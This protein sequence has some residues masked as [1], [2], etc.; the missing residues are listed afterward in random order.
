MAERFLRGGRL[1]T[2]R[3]RRQFHRCG[4][5]GVAVQPPR[6]GKAGGGLVARRRRGGGHRAG[7]R[8]GFRPD[9]QT[10][11]HRPRPRSRHRHRTV[12]VGQLRRPHDGHRRS[13]VSAAC[14]PSDSPGTT[15]GGWRS[16]PGSPGICSAS[17]CTARASIASRR[18]T[19]CSATGSWTVVQDQ[20]SRTG[21]RGHE[22]RRR[23]QQRSVRTGFWSGST[24]SG[25]GARAC[26]TRW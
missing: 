6:T 11:D 1:Y 22:H 25:S 8:R 5:P 15:A 19:P 14:S 23:R 4:D 20:M 12:H 2:P 10:P 18:A 7:Q 13:Q 9:L 17:P 16:S 21:V 3:Q 26:S 24:S